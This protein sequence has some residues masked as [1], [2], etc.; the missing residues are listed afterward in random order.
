M[1]KK[2]ILTVAVALFATEILAQWGLAGTSART[3]ATVPSV[4]VGTFTNLNLPLAR[5]EVD[6]F[7]SASPT[8]TLNGFL[9]RTDGNQTVDNHWQLFTGTSSTAQTERFRIRT[10]AG[11]NGYDTW[12]E[13]TQAGSE[14]DI[15]LLT[16]EVQIRS[17]LKRL[18]QWCELA[19]ALADEVVMGDGTDVNFSAMAQLNRRLFV[20][21]TNGF[22]GMGHRFRESAGTFLLPNY[23]LH[24][25]DSTATS[26]YQQWTNLNTGSLVNDGLRI[27]LNATVSHEIR[28]FDNGVWLDIAQS[29][30]VRMR[31]RDQP[32]YNGLNGN[33][34]GAVNRIM[35]PLRLADVNVV[36]MCMMQLGTNSPGNIARPWMN[37]GTAYGTNADAMYVGWM[38]RANATG[39][40]TQSDAV[41]SWGCQRGLNNNS[42]FSDN[43][44]ILFLEPTGNIADSA[45]TVQGKEV[46]RIE[47]FSG[48]VGIGNFSIT[49]T[50]PPGNASYMGAKLDID[51]DLRIRSVLQDDTL[52]QVLVRDP[53]DLGRVRWRDAA[54]LI[55][56]CDWN[57]TGV[58]NLS[59]GYASACRSGQV[60]VG[61][62]I[63]TAKF[64]TYANTSI[65]T[66]IYGQSGSTTASNKGVQGHAANVAAVENAG[67]YGTAHGGDKCFG[68][69]FRATNTNGENSVGSYAEANNPIAGGNNTGASGRAG[70]A[71]TNYGLY[72]EANA[73]GSAFSAGV[74]AAVVGTGTATWAVYAAG[75]VFSTGT[76]Q[77]SDSKLKENI[78]PIANATDMIMRLQP[79]SYTYNTAKYAQLNLPSGPQ[80]GLIA[81]ELE[82]VLPEAVKHTMHPAQF[83]SEGKKISDDVSFAAVN[84]TAL[85]PYI[86][87]TIQEQQNKITSLE[88]LVMDLQKARS[89]IDKN[90][91]E[92]SKLD[93]KLSNKSIILNQNVP[94]PF[95]EQTTITYNIDEDFSKAQILFYDANGKLIQTTDITTTGAG[96][97]NVFADDLSSGIYSY[98]L[99]VDGKIIDTKKMV[100]Q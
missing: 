35:V 3:N 14:A 89:Y 5:L 1:H 82:Q 92:T 21:G 80:S 76:Y 13:R 25:H 90:T 29:D 72:G 16:A 86:I 50:H 46:F 31:F 26:I 52:D 45:G 58:D 77:F 63:G 20:H 4:G 51:G 38:E 78:A 59:T 37:V 95:A 100:K 44:R 8:G 75:N 33:N 79:K 6:N 65:G 97:L 42:P 84:Y 23:Q 27:G 10:L 94:N 2:I 88:T 81:Q 19:G 69:F 60:F 66:A 68:G 36:P 74:Y 15:R 41:I 96:Q 7:L 32:T 85:I 43:F 64:N 70:G 47:P 11:G 62:S 28:S 61:D 18:G 99:V 91:T 9:F 49:G 17:R 30:T 24:L 98:V 67:V 53:N 39:A 56:E 34:Y 73:N 87:Q 40:T 22:V 83:D 71:G 57:L 55:G 93:V 48:N 12:L 54:T